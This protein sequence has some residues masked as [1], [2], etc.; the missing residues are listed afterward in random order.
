MTLSKSKPTMKAES[1]AT[2]PITDLTN[3]LKDVSD[4]QDSA[5]P[6]NAENQLVTGWRLHLSTLS[7]LTLIFLV[8]MESSIAS[9]TLLSI[10]NQFGGYERSS[11]V[12][13]AYMLTY[14]GEFCDCI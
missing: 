3:G 8:Q 10:T 12:F 1:G 9:T 13:T 11:W 7:L 4:G 2:A 6:I 5:N 14:C